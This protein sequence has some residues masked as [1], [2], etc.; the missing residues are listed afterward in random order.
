M[1]SIDIKKLKYNPKLIKSYFKQNNNIVTVNEDVRVIFPS[2]FI[3]K[4]L[5]SLGSTVRLVS[6][7]CI[8]DNKNNYAVVVA[9]IYSE[10]SP[11]KIEDIAIEGDN[12]TMLHFPKGSVY[13]TNT[14]LI[15]SDN[16]LYDLFEMM[17]INGNIPWY[18]SYT[19]TSDLFSETSK[20]SGSGIGNDITLFEVVTAIVSRN[21][22]DLTEFWRHTLNKG[23]KGSSLSYIGLSN[24]F[25]A[26]DNT[27]AKIIGSF[28]ESGLTNAINE[29]ET[30]PTD[31]VKVLRY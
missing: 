5:A 7:Y 4:E 22:R 12:F 2:I 27:G 11:D 18:M 13:M 31:S 19:L 14:K 24:I 25:Y 29:K 21:S 28:F 16:F 8:L 10:L 20:Y 23:V 30:K 9:P 26:F 17:F 3:N 1:E 6:I 15:V